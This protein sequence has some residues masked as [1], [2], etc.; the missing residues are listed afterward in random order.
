M[1]LITG[2][3]VDNSHIEN[4]KQIFYEFDKDRNGYIDREEYNEIVKNY[5]SKSGSVE[6]SLLNSGSFDAWDIN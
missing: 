2:L 6:G 4:L 1:S 3:I 5:R